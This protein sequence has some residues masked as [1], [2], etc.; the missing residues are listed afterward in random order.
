MR[1]VLSVVAAFVFGVADFLLGV[2]GEMDSSVITQ[3]RIL[4]S[5]RLDGVL[6]DEAHVKLRVCPQSTVYRHMV[7][8]RF[9]M[10]DERKVTSLCLVSRSDAGRAVSATTL[11]V[12]RSSARRFHKRRRGLRFLRRLFL[13]TSSS[14]G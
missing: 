12:A 3:L 7:L 13:A 5:D 9:W 1:S 4:G 8:L 11:V 14:S 2:E 6:R 10:G